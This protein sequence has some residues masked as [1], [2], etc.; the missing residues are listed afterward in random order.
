MP[1][2]ECRQVPRQVTK[3]VCIQ[4]PT[5]EP[6][7]E[8]RKVPRQECDI[9]ETSETYEQCSVVPQQLPAQSQVMVNLSSDDK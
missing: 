7:Q 1:Q 6:R 4:V 2:E 8:C 3:E 5:S 9:R